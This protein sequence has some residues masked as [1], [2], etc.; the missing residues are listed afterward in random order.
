MKPCLWMINNIKMKSKQLY[1]NYLNILQTDAL[2]RDENE[3]IPNIIGFVTSELMVLA[4]RMEIINLTLGFIKKKQITFSCHVSL[5]AVKVKTLLYP[6]RATI[7][8]TW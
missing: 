8:P 6:Q 7:V 5:T 3:N 1:N 2:T 4:M